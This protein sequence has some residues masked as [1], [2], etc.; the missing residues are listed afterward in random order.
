MVNLTVEMQ[1]MIKD[2]FPFLATT[3]ENGYP[4]IGPK[5]SL[6]V[7]D[8]NHLIYYEHTFRHAYHNLQ[9][10]QHAAVAVVDREA[11]KGFRFEGT[12]HIHEGDAQADKILAATK[13]FDRFPRAAVVIID[14]ERIYKLDNNLEAGTRLA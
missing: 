10:N 6:Q 5:G 14:V 1:K 11:Q 3:D 8:E 2:Q 9:H 7:L 13:I 12:A 4:K